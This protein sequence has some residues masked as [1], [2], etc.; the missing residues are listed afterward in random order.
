MTVGKDLP[1]TSDTLA[2]AFVKSAWFFLVIG[3]ILIGISPITDSD[4]F[5]HLALGRDFF[6]SGSLPTVD[7]FIV[8]QFRDWTTWHEWGAYA[9]FY[10]V[11]SLL[12]YAGL[13]ALKLVLVG[14]ALF[15]AFRWIRKSNLL[16]SWPQFLISFC[17]VIALGLRFSERT[18]LFGDAL[19]A[20]TI[21]IILTD[22]QSEVLLRKIWFLPLLIFFWVNLHGSFPLAWVVVTIWMCSYLL[23]RDWIGVKARMPVVIACFGAPFLN[24][25]GFEG[26]V[27]PF[28]FL[29]FKQEFLQKFVFEWKPTFGASSAIFMEVWFFGLFL[30][31]SFLLILVSF[32]Q[33]PF[34]N[35]IIYVL[36]A[37]FL[38]ALGFS[39][40]RFIP[41]AIL[42]LTLIISSI[43][44]RMPLVGIKRSI[45]LWT[46][47][48]GFIALLVSGHYLR[49][50]MP[51]QIGIGIDHRI[52]PTDKTIDAIKKAPGV[53]PVRNDFYFGCYLAWMLDG[54]RKIFIHGYVTDMRVLQE[55]YSGVGTSREKFDLDVNK[56]GTRGVLLDRNSMSLSYF[57]ILKEHPNWYAAA[58]DDASVLFVPKF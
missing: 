19:L 37:A 4:V 55:Y 35:K 18:S 40:N 16:S 45:C 46:I 38:V 11:Y 31:L 34:R 5:M 57:N 33:G 10:S 36:L 1:G 43:P 24:P 54:Q 28:N 13:T 7:P 22:W 15:P 9:L 58:V 52:F 48:L 12:G 30:F 17:G 26:V 51:H 56:W 14:I 23:N 20:L 44:I 21:A 53:G 29:S 8:S 32:K 3:L 47:S 49:A 50:G 39:A 2:Q 27:S 42:G 6:K 41:T 25:H